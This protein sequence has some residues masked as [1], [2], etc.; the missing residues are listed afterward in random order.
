[1]QRSVV[2]IGNFDGV[3]AGHAAL[4][5][6]AR[7]LADKHGARALAI[8]FDPHPAV[9]LRPGLVPER[10]CPVE[11]RAELL[12]AAGAD[13]V[14]VLR[15]TPE[16]LSQPPEGFVEMLVRQHAPLAFVEGPDFRF[17]KARAGDLNLLAALGAAHGF[18]VE[19]AAPVSAV[20][21]DQ[22]IVACSSTMARW[23]VGHG[24]VLDAWAVLGRPFEIEG[25]V[26]RGDRRG[27]TLGMPTANIAPRAM[28]PADGV[29]AGVATAPNGHRY[30]AAVSVGTKP[31]FTDAPAR[32]AEAFLIDMERAHEP[33]AFAP[34]GQGEGAWRALPGLPE[35]GW[36]LRIA[37]VGWVRE[38][39][40][41]ADVGALCA[42]MTRDVGRV[43]G[44]ARDRANPELAA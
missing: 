3:H 16:L 1:M 38:Q 25:E 27:R 42:Q 4:I 39:A 10:L 12:R 30:A 8:T 34:A 37:L 18:A 15:P 33:E 40:R 32:T 44:I 14:V 23:L 43:L 7:A 13:E 35:Y 41:F 20:L 26:V 24:R 36:P 21:G 6:R 19:P 28:L 22:S 11:R 5:A 31:T 2:S 17:G 9:V 29:Y